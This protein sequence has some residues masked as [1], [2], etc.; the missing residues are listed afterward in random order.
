MTIGEF[1]TFS[2]FD[3]S[4]GFKHSVFW[5]FLFMACLSAVELMCV[6]HVAYRRGINKTHSYKKFIERLGFDH[7]DSSTYSHTDSSRYSCYALYLTLQPRWSNP[8]FSLLARVPLFIKISALEE[9]VDVVKG[10]KDI[11][12]H[13]YT[14]INNE[15]M[16]LYVVIWG[17]V[18]LFM[19]CPVLILILCCMLYAIRRI[20]DYYSNM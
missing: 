19:L 6:F 2:F 20:V 16:L 11:V 3:L 1:F 10:V 18:F 12:Y 7:T 5:L 14:N 13:F 4:F 15:I 8:I 17:F 9:K